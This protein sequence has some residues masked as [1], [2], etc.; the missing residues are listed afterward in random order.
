MMM[1]MRAVYSAVL[2]APTAREEKTDEQQEDGKSAA[3]M[4]YSRVARER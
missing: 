2:E 3:K 4:M 1:K